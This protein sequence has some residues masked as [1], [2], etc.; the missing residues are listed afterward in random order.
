MS[1]HVPS[2]T[3]KDVADPEEQRMNPLTPLEAQQSLYFCISTILIDGNMSIQSF[4]DSA[5]RR[6]PVLELA[7]TIH[8][9]ADR[10][11]DGIPYSPAEVS[12][13]FRDGNSVSSRVDQAIGGPNNPLSTNELTSKF[14]ENTT[15]MQ[16]E[17]ILKLIN[18]L[19]SIERITDITELIIEKN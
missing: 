19:E 9:E 3:F 6:R 18:H 16:S 14:Q 1:V 2:L 10:Q 17:E 13:T 15:G 5:I 4:S 12:I 7:K 11:M 8:V